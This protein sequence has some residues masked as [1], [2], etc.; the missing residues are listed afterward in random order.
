MGLI[1]TEKVMIVMKKMTIFGAMKI[2]IYVAPNVI[3]DLS[4]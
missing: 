1:L 4:K 2:H 3:N